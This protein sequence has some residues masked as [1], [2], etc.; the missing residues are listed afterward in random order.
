MGTHQS[1][2]QTDTVANQ[3]VRYLEDRGIR[4][5]FGLCGHTN[6]AVLAAMANSK[7]H[8]VNVRHEQISAHAADGYARI[9]G[10]ASVLLTHLSPGLT[11]AA[12]GVANAALDCIPMVVISGDVP[13]HY[14]GK[15]P[16]QEVNLHADSSQHEIYRPF[17]KRAWRVDR[18]ELMP[19]IL[20]KAFTLAESGQPGPV[21][22]NVP[23]DVFST[24]I[25]LR[26]W[27]RAR[28][29]TRAL[30]K[31]AL[32]EATAREIV[33]RLAD[34]KAP[35]IYA[36]GGVALARAY[37]ELRAFVDHMQIP[38]AHSLMG[39]G[40]LPDD[41]PLVLGMTGFWGTKFTNQQ[42]LGADWILALG[43]R[44]KEA[45]S[46]SWYPE[47]TFDIGPD[48][49]KLIHIDIEP[50]EIGRNYPA[51]IGAI[52]DLKSA[53]K[54]LNRVAQDLLPQGRK[55]P[56][57]AARIAAE[58]KTFSAGNLELQTSDAFPMMPERILADLR[59]VM[60]RD[61]IL[62]SDVGWNKNGVAQQFDIL[63]PGSILIPGG[64]ATMGFGPPA[65]IGAKIAAPERTVISLVGDGGF[66]QNPAMLATAV[67]ENAPV[68]WIIM[69][70]NAYGTI[71]GLQKANYGLVHGTT[72][73]KA[74]SLEEQTP[75]YASIARAYG[76]DGVRIQTA[77]AFR[78]ALE[79][80]I[81]SGRPT[82]ID[83]AM[84]NTPTPTS[85]HWNILDIY[86]PDGNAGH[87]A[88]D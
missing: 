23:M 86:S 32:D 6:I 55:A 26:L 59:A 56:E 75:D 42:T 2:L 83:V 1:P 54:V 7:L 44:F 19:E 43:A 82:V 47:Y 85:G 35:V 39:K 73:A 64:F 15:H 36:G 8:F 14:Y 60:P 11:N 46:S 34:A 30:A 88:T 61:A 12:T 49:S 67:A 84:V 28:A 10:K 71:A 62:T 51:E 16:H 17:V 78:P 68:I 9:T 63:T 76:C 37:D 27:E 79:K 87:V 77:D 65:A 48:G 40:V 81:M 53:L 80:A 21:L 22:I 45:D 20:E 25:D 74:A 4:H 69:N 38:V 33:A 52:A 5:V 57:L 70:N 72:F 18:A 13:T 3:L 66:G 41:H 58:R 29:N 50:Q 24:Q 31:P